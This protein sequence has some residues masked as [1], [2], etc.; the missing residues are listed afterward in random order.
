[1][2]PIGIALLAVAMVALTA[3]PGS[4]QYVVSA[5][6]GLVNLAEGQVQLDG[7]SLESSLTHYPDIKEGSVL[8]TEEGRAEVLLT[9]GVTLRLG[10]HASLKMITNRLIDTRVELLSGKAVVE[11]DEIAKDTSVTVVVNNAAVSLPKAGIYRFDSGLARLRVYKGEAAVQADSE[12]RLVGA[13]REYTL[14]DADATVGKFSTDDTD[15]LDNWSHRRA[16]LMAMANVSGAN[17]FGSSQRWYSPA[18]YMGLGMPFMGCSGSTFGFWAYNPWYDMYTYIPCY[19]MAY[20]PYGYGYGFVSPFSSQPLPKQGGVA[21]GP[22]RGPIHR[23]TRGPVSLAANSSMRGAASFASRPPMALTVN[24]SHTPG[25]RGGT[26]ATRSY[27]SASSGHGGFAGYSGAFGGSVAQ[28]GYSGGGG[29][30]STGGG[31]SAGG[32]AGPAGHGG[33]G[34]GGSSAGSS[35]GR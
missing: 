5:K 24:G 4:A 7:H 13:G 11:A 14:G 6:A 9:P 33:A 10:D 19:G 16:E 2:K 28:G 3:T 35:R 29:S 8:T 17:W 20:S 25:F 15:A 34:G 31:S 30:M 22:V 26:G 27:S 21:K 23:P 32:G 1:M 12:T 18:G